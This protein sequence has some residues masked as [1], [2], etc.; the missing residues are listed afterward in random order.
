M[1][2]IVM[3][4]LL[5]YPIIFFANV[6]VAYI[7]PGKDWNVFSENGDDGDDCPLLIPMLVWPLVAAGF[8]LYG[9]WWVL[10]H[11]DTGIRG[12]ANQMGEGRNSVVIDGVRHEALLNRIKELESQLGTKGEDGKIIHWTK[13]EDNNWEQKEKTAGR[14]R[15]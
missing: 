2:I 13:D 4:Y 3:M 10:S 1:P 11:C 9:L 6:L 8:T 15:I 5:G 7:W 14:L 12:K